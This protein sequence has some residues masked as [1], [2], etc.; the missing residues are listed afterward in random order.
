MD[1]P[2]RRHCDEL[3]DE[4]NFGPSYGE[5]INLN[6][7]LTQDV[8]FLLSTFL[9]ALPEPL[10]DASIFEPLFVWCVQPSCKRE[11][12]KR[13][14]EAK[15]EEEDRI[16]AHRR[17]EN[18]K[19]T[20]ILTKTSVINWTKDEEKTNE[21]SETPQVAIAVVLFKA[22]PTAHF[23]LLVYLIRFFTQ[24]PICPENGMSLEEC[25]NKFSEKMM[26]NTRI[27][28][29]QV[30]LWLLTRW[31]RI[32]D[33]LFSASRA[34]YEEM[35]RKCKRNAENPPQTT[36]DTRSPG[37]RKE[38][39][40]SGRALMRSTTVG[41]VQSYDINSADAVLGLGRGG[42]GKG[43]HRSTTVVSAT[44]YDLRRLSAISTEAGTQIQEKHC[45][46][47]VGTPVIRSN[48][49]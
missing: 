15:I 22:L 34:A 37:S 49:G 26:G 29:H 16:A 23:A 8:C 7:E 45:P 31:P 38:L 21:D 41:S 2:N 11:D 46:A 40:G 47:F 44:P 32:S 3:L 14:I 13:K 9:S 5:K 30:M 25:A 12:A 39:R 6:E 18:V 35:K 33:G 10:I 17:G 42:S 20:D 43:L 24:L 36:G 27:K 48:N 19:L 28:S 4:F 1:C